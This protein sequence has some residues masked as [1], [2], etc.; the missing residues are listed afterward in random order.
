MNWY[1][2][3]LKEYATFDGRAIRKEYWMFFLFNILFSILAL[4]LDQVLGTAN[5]DTGYG[6]F[7]SLYGLAVFLPSIAVG[8]R[9]L[10]DIGKSG[11][12]LFISF[13]PFIG[14]IW[15]LVLLATEGE[16]GE[17]QYGPNPKENGRPVLEH[18]RRSAA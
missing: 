10:H 14:G 9:R 4:I 16:P 11:W 12:W 15:L 5:N 8:V 1:I 6:I 2:A 13:V 7:Y 17:N 3:A 18:H